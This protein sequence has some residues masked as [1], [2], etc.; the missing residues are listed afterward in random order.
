MVLTPKIAAR[1]QLCTIVPLSTTD[2]YK[3]M[4]YHKRIRI[5]LELPKEWGDRERWIKGDMVNAVGFHRVDLLRLG[6]NRAGQRIY[7]T[8]PLPYEM[9][10]IVQQCALHGMG[11]SSLTKHI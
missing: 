7:Q 3:V 9:L 10:K 2:P 8:S 1:A 4:P 11:L 6:K 5:P